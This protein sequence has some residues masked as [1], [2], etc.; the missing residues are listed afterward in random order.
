MFLCLPLVRVFI[1][2]GTSTDALSTSA[3]LAEVLP[4]IPN[5]GIHLTASIL[6]LQVIRVDVGVVTNSASMWRIVLCFRRFL[7]TIL[8]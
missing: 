3:C 1:R 6:V 2:Y 8:K 5:V 4:P 7:Q